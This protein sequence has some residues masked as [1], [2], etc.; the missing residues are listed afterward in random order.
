[1]P[2]YTPLFNTIVQSSI[3]GES[4]ATRI[5]WVT[6]LAMKDRSGCVWASVGGLARMAVLTNEE[7]QEALTTLESPDPDSRRP[8]HSGRRIEKIDG[9]WKI[10]NH[11]FYRD[12]ARLEAER[13]R[14]R[15]WAR[16]HRLREKLSP[17]EASL[18]AIVDAR[19]RKAEDAYERGDNASAEKFAEPVMESLKQDAQ[20]GS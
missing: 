5:L 8:D 17:A 14:K 7:T 19:A 10:L 12:L 15:R 20:T 16:E 2:N 11:E 18:K 9:G 4:K 3:W 13:L 1:M 6:L